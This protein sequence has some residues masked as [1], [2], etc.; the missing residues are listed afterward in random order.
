VVTTP[1]GSLTA[2]EIHNQWLKAVNRALQCDRLLTDKFRFGPLAANKQLI[3][4]TWSG[5]L[6]N[7]DSLLGFSG[8]VAH[9]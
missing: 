2:T 3:L 8:Y 6:K 7:E 5:I 1:D 4:N 9:D